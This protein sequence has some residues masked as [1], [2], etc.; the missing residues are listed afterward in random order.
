MKEKNSATMKSLPESERPYEKCLRYGPAYLSDAELLAVI[1]RTGS[2]GYTALQMAADILRLCPYQ[3]GLTGILHLSAQDLR[4]VTGI[5]DVKAVQVLCIGELSRRIARMESGRTLC[6]EDPSSVA[7]YYMEE[8]RH[9]EQE[10]VRCMMLDTRGRMLGE[11]EVHRGTVS[12]APLSAREVFLR[13]LSYHAV[14]IVLVHNHPSGNPAPSEED[15]AVTRQLM[16]AGD[17]VGIR[18]LDHIII[19][20]HTYVSL[21]TEGALDAAESADAGLTPYA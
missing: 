11:T 20:D 1:L 14:S 3:E 5:G 13:A 10:T 17:L 12:N 2:Y 18:L 9:E 21:L 4:S 19:G 7:A 15:I 6:F 16:R 8:L